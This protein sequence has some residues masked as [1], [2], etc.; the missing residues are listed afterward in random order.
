[1]TKLVIEKMFSD[2]TLVQNIF[3]ALEILFFGNDF[4]R[5]QNCES[6]DHVV[7]HGERHRF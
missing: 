5:H 4:W 7:K 2:E 3:L 1:M 6:F